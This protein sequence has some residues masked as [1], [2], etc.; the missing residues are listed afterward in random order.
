MKISTLGAAVVPSVVVE[1]L[2][3]VEVLVVVVGGCVVVVVVEVV[4][5]HPVKPELVIP[6]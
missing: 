6:I 1:V 4:A 3:D 2:V 5:G